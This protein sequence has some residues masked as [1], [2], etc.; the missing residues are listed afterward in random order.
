[1]VV[2]KAL[3]PDFGIKPTGTR[4]LHG[5]S[6]V[7]MG[8][9][10]TDIGFNLP[11]ASLLHQSAAVLP[12][13]FISQRTGRSVGALLGYEFFRDFV[14][15]IDFARERM[16]LYDPRWFEYHGR[17]EVIPLQFEQNLPYVEAS[18]KMPDGNVASGKFV[19]DLGS[20]IP[21]MVQQSYATAHAWM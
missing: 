17:G 16:N 8:E 1:A 7:E 13:D 20:E 14:V 15:E 21:V 4:R 5:A 18:L 10:A 11:G 2:N 19:I 12:L 9:T 3:I 6:G